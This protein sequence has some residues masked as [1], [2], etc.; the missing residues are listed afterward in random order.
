MLG[1]ER[2]V[3]NAQSD[4]FYH[5]L[6][7]QHALGQLIGAIDGAIGAVNRPILSFV[8]RIHSVMLIDSPLAAWMLPSLSEVIERR[9]DLTE[10]LQAAASGGCCL[11]ALLV[12]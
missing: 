4:L 8:L 10:P 11:Y 12:S 5:V 2:S 7:Y 9:P 6:R 1:R 3:A